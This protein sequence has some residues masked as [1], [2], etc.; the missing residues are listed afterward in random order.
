MENVFKTENVYRAKDN[1]YQ[2][3]ELHVRM[4]LKNKSLDEYQ[5]FM[6]KLSEFMKEACK[7]SYELSFE[8][9]DKR[10]EAHWN[11]KEF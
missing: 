2:K 6:R 7:T 5:T 11:E 9:T 1:G 10:G 3:S 4:W 8:V